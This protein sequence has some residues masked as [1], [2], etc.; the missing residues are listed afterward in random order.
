MYSLHRSFPSL[1]GAKHG[2]LP[3]TPV[4]AKYLILLLSLWALAGQAFAQTTR[5]NGNWNSGSTWSG[6]SAPGTGW[7]T[8]N[9]NHEVQRNGNWTVTGTMNVNG[10]LELTGSVTVSGGSHL[11][12]YGEL[13]VTGS[14]TLNSSLTIHPGGKLT[15]DDDL[16]VVSS[17]YLNVGNSNSPPLYADLIVKGNLNSQSSGDMVVHPNGRVAVFGDMTASG[18][19]TFLRIMNGGQVFVNGSIDMSGGTGNTIDNQ[20]TT[21]G[22]VGLYIGGTVNFSTWDGFTGA[23]KTA[24]GFQDGNNSTYESIDN[25][26]RDNDPF[27]EWLQIQ[28][29]SPLPVTLLW[30]DAK[31]LPHGVR[32]AWQTGSESNNDFFTIEKSS[33]GWFFTEVAEIAG[34]GTTNAK[35]SYEWTDHSPLSGLT[36]YRLRQ[37]DYDGTTEYIG[38]VSVSAEES[39]L[40]VRPNPVARNGRLSVV[41]SIPENASWVIYT[42]D[43]R[44]QLQ[45][46]FD[47]TFSLSMDNISGGHYI[48]SI[49]TSNHRWFSRF[50]VD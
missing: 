3:A 36:Y 23:N 48:L 42:L 49:E 27:F 44:K 46:V 21:A 34:S 28:D 17:Q 39:E 5:A 19:G 40:Q 4:S 31:K 15:V 37:T 20:N 7:T 24:Q 32:L 10:S 25:L 14:V 8:I 43:G 1:R 41:G 30:F 2:L 22:F 35:S 11:H 50:I 18:G 12:V 38:L 33:D 47:N 16:T 26:Q 9:V 6:G 13:H 45:G 29:D